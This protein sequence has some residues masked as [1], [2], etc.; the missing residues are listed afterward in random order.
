MA[1]MDSDL[2]RFFIGARLDVLAL[3]GLISAGFFFDRGFLRFLTDRC[4]DSSRAFLDLSI[5]KNRP[6]GTR[7]LH[8]TH[9]FQGSLPILSMFNNAQDVAVFFGFR[10]GHVFHVQTQHQGHQQ[11]VFAPAHLPVVDLFG[12]LVEL[13]RGFDNPVEVHHLLDDLFDHLLGVV[14][15]VH[16][17]HVLVKV[18]AEMRHGVVHDDDHGP[19]HVVC[20]SNPRAVVVFVHHDHFDQTR[21]GYVGLVVHGLV[22]QVA[23]NAEHYIGGFQPW[24]V[25]NG[26]DVVYQQL[27]LRNRSPVGKCL[28]A[29]NL[30]QKKERAKVRGNKKEKNKRMEE[31]QESMAFEKNEKENFWRELFELKDKEGEDIFNPLRYTVE[32]G[33]ILKDFDPTK[34]RLDVVQKIGSATGAELRMLFSEA[35]SAVASKI[36]DRS[37]EYIQNEVV[38]LEDKQM[39]FVKQAF[40]YTVLSFSSPFQMQCCSGKIGGVEY[41]GI[42][43]YEMSVFVSYGLFNLRNEFVRTMIAPQEFV[44]EV[45]SLVEKGGVHEY[46]Q[47]NDPRGSQ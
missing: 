9:L 35:L 21:A 6:R 34:Y 12:F 25:S 13:D 37:K 47:C 14:L 4:L 45:R 3:A 43:P 18:Q 15:A 24:N 19:L 23:F 31:E 38:T 39:D 1:F 2:L 28:G 44:K 10:S 36:N 11:V 42:D 5:L 40:L 16:A 8:S 7:C 32:K 27:G 41:R 46:S 22:A 33:A 26:F 29:N 30:L 17:D 20:G